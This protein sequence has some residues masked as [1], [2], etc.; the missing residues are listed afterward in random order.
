MAGVN[1]VDNV[2]YAQYG[3]VT[4]SRNLDEQNN[5]EPINFKAAYRDPEAEKKAAEKRNRVA[6]G[7]VAA[8]LIALGVFLLRGKITPV[9]KKG[10]AGIT[11]Y[12][13]KA[14]EKC[15]GLL[16]KTVEKVTP[17]L[18][19]V[20]DATKKVAGKVVDVVSPLVTKVADFAKRIF[21]K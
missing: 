19:K 12:V 2:N 7:V 15:K 16:S 20:V 1:G 11:P 10:I 13:T 9:A 5:S 4:R 3:Y 8:A 6:T 21:K 14:L 18:T 17:M